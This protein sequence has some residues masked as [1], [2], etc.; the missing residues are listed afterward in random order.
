[1]L[2]TLGAVSPML[3]LM[4]TTTCFQPTAHSVKRF[5]ERFAGNITCQEAARRIQCIARTAHW[6]RPA[7]GGADIYATHGYEL[8]VRDE[9]ILTIYRVDTRPDAYAA[10]A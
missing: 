3:R 7:P 1:M 5:I 2:L 4:R 10:Q 9:R 8:V 6:K